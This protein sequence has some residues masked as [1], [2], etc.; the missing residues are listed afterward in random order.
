TPID[1]TAVAEV[2][3]AMPQL[4]S[5]LQLSAGTAP[6]EE[7]LDLLE[8][9]ITELRDARCELPAPGLA[10]PSTA[11]LPELFDWALDRL[12]GVGALTLPQGAGGEIALTPLG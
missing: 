3:E 8:Q 5:V 9:R 4:L 2:V 10:A 1:P 11:P 7:L 6:R 12:A